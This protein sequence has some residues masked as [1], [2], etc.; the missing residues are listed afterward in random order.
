V[1]KTQVRIIAPIAVAQW[2]NLAGR[3]TEIGKAAEHP[4]AFF[5]TPVAIL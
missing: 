2:A 1:V 3:L 5:K 4:A